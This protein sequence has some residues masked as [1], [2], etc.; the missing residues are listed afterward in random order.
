MF[1]LFERNP[2]VFFSSVSFVL[3]GEK[4]AIALGYN[5][6][7][8]SNRANVVSVHFQVNFRA[9]RLQPEYKFDTELKFR[10][11]QHVLEMRA[12]LFPLGLIMT[13]N[14]TAKESKPSVLF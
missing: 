4:T 9:V 14:Q 12:R 10:F 8:E 2:V 3:A 13:L 7:S 6:Q 1:S 11:R 5:S